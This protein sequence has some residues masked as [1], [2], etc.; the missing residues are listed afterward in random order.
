MSGRIGT[1]AQCGQRYDIPDSVTALQV[2][3]RACGGTV[4]IP[5]PAAAAPPPATPPKKERKAAKVDKKAEK[6]AKPI[7]QPLGKPKAAAPRPKEAKAVDRAKTK[8]PK[9]PVV[10]PKAA[11]KPVAPVKP[12][13]P[14]KKP[15][16]PPKPV[17][18]PVNPVV[19]PKRAAAP[20]PKPVVP[21]QKPAPPKLAA[22]KS[23]PAKPAAAASAEKKSSAADII[24][25]AKAKREAE[26]KAA[27]RKP[28]PAAKPAGKS[29]PKPEA[30]ASAA[31]IIAKAK[32]KREAQGAAPAAA[33]PAPAKP[34]ARKAPAAGGG[35][36]KVQS[37]GGGRA[38]RLKEELAKPKSKAPMIIGSVVVLIMVAVSAWAVF[39][40]KDPPPA[41]VE[42][43]TAQLPNQ[44]QS[45]GT[46]TPAAGSGAAPTKTPILPPSSG[47]RAPAG[48]DAPSAGEEGGAPAGEGGGGDSAAADTKPAP[49]PTPAGV[50]DWSAPEAGGT[51]SY[52]GITD[53]AIIV[54]AEVPKLGPP[55][56][57]AEELWSEVV[58]DLELYL[59]DAGAMS[60]RAGRRLVDDYPREAFPAI[61]NAMLALDYAEND[62]HRIGAGLN[63]L[64]SD[65]GKG[66]NFGWSTVSTEEPDSDAWNKVAVSNKKVVCAWY[67][68]WVTSW[69]E[70]DAAWASFTKSAVEEQPAAAP[71]GS[72]IVGPDEDL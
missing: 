60:N 32:A 19:T 5:P 47:D 57:T 26:A 41:P 24:A 49:K 63:D 20:P 16:I 54:L 56:G 2:K 10:A 13:V 65:I 25:K 27:A 55:P 37:T 40:K 39:L 15:V 21:V 1:C 4:D 7:A 35:R 52:R 53:P 8:V 36:P 45:G 51:I 61:V 22:A 12:V 31:D 28:A 6:K 17:S 33:K 59:E 68:K 14:P 62:G 70:N 72:G 48:A 50:T 23:A 64:L 43:Q 34:A 29:A 18:K 3:C 67:N 11:A 30:K 44:G 9:Q 42:D 71:G 58:E 46:P 38:A 66:T 69:A